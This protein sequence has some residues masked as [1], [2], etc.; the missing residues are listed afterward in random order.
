M[1][2]KKEHTKSKLAVLIGLVL[3]VSLNCL[4][5][6]VTPISAPGNPVGVPTDTRSAPTDTPQSVPLENPPAGGSLN[7]T[8]PWLLIKTSQGLW[9]ANPDG[10]ALSQLTNVDYWRGNLRQAIQPDGNQVV[11]LTPGNYDFHHMAL[12]LLSLPDGK[13]T[14]ITDLTSASTEAYTNSGPG[15]SGFEALRAIG[16]QASYAWSPDGTRLAF[17][18]VMDGPSADIYL[19]DTR[20]G[21]ITRVSQDPAQ[22]FAPSWS[23]DGKRLVYLAANGFGTGAGGSMSG[24]WMANGDGSNPTQLFPADSAGEMIEGWLDDTTVLLATWNQPCGSQKLRL[25]DLES[26]QVSMLY[27]DCF[28]SATADGHY[29]AALYSTSSGVYMLTAENRTP[30]QVDTAVNASIDPRHAGDQVFTV[31]FASGGVATFGSLSQFDH[32]VSPVKASA[33]QMD[34]AEYGAIWGWTSRD[35]AQP[36][37]WI[38]GPGMD[39]GQ[40]FEGPAILPIWSQ[41]N[42][43]LFFAPQDS[44]G[45]VIYLAT[46]A[47]SYSDLHQVNTLAVSPTSAAWLGGE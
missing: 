11:F 31:R 41:D 40:I 34:V 26:K 20:T 36:G 43:L 38:T 22:D 6:S 3:V 13:V 9:A 8:G 42:N 21:V 46:F 14:K 32:Q 30:T 27:D 24:V 5:G 12:K 45:C 29:G 19:Y 17:S 44:G 39:I 4:P 10:G 47:S 25:Y 7:A 33:G 28:T 16:E 35:A 18:G 2:S 37:V 1:K 23:P 15:D